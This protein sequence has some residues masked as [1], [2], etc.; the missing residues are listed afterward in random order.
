MNDWEEIAKQAWD[1]ANVGD[2]VRA[3][4]I[5]LPVLQSTINNLAKPGKTREAEVFWA[6]V[7]AAAPEVKDEIDIF[8]IGML[9]TA[10]GAMICN[11]FDNLETVGTE[12]RQR[13]IIALV[14]TALTM[15]YRSKNP[16]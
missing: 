16:A 7:A 15:F 8:A 1:A 5:A 13:F 6:R 3:G 14:E 11:V 4:T 10:T 12:R 2:M 9:A